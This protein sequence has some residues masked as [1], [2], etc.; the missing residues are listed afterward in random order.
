MVENALESLQILCFLIWNKSMTFPWPIRFTSSEDG[1]LGEGMILIGKGILK[2]HTTSNRFGEWK[3]RRLKGLCHEV[4]M[5][6]LRLRSY[7]NSN[8]APVFLYRFESF[9][10]WEITLTQRSFPI[11]TVAVL[12]VKRISV[13]RAEAPVPLYGQQRVIATVNSPHNLRWGAQ[14]S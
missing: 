10:S 1:L 8:F 13:V 7:W 9:R 11:S 4:P 14:A 3:F 12:L 6:E 5:C 2:R